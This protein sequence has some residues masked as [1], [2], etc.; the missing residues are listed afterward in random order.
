MSNENHTNQDGRLGGFI[1]LLFCLLL[2]L[3]LLFFDIL[4][5]SIYLIFIVPS[6][7]PSYF[8]LFVFS[9]LSVDLLFFHVLFIFSPPDFSCFLCLCLSLCLFPCHPLLT[10]YLL[11]CFSTFLFL[12]APLG[13]ILDIFSPVI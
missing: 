4:S 10:L 13:R 7:R 1:S 9:F 8:S 11:H 2:H 3:C 5:R 12:Q 6:I